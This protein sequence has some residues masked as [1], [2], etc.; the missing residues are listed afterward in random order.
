MGDYAIIRPKDDKSSQ[1]A[2]DW[3]DDLIRKLNAAGHVKIGDVD[4]WSPANTKNILALL[5]GSAD[6]VC[7]F[8]HGK[9]NRWLTS[10]SATLDTGNVTGAKGQP[11]NGRAIVSIACK[12]S[13][14][15]GPAAITAGVQAWL[16]FTI[17]VKVIAPHNFIDPIGDAIV[18]GLAVLGNQGTVQ[19]ARDE[20]AANLGQLVIDY[21]TGQYAQHPEAEIGYFA[22]MSMRDHVVVNGTAN[23]QPLP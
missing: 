8:G 19:Q 3:A 11:A 23:I 15:L 6:L 12:T 5:S 17:K 20:L 18:N 22:A 16:G 7:Y 9:E 10:N 1:Q 13:C 21:D 2:S 4:D 14:Q